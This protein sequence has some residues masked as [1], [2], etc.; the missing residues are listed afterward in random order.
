MNPETSNHSEKH[1]SDQDNLDVHKDREK[2]YPKRKPL[3]L[4]WNP[5]LTS[6]PKMNQTVTWSRE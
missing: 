4:S 2:V 6:G 1:L 3:D 5:R